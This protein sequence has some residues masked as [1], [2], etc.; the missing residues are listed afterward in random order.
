METAKY[1]ICTA[2][3]FLANRTHM[4]NDIPPLINIQMIR[5]P[6]ILL[7]MLSDPWHRILIFNLPGI[8]LEVLQDR[9]HFPKRQRNILT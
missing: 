1:A 9:W 4:A 2:A 7:R 8:V 5:Q 3:K 6:Y